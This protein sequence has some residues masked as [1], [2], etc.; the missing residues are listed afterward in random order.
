[1]T[2]VI[3]T[4]LIMSLS[5]G[6]LALLLFVLK[7]L[8][9]DRL[10]KSAQYY[11]WLVVFAALLLPVSVI[12]VLPGDSPLPVAPVQSVVELIVVPPEPV[13]P[14]SQVPAPAVFDRSIT[15]TEPE[16][17][18]TASIP[19]PLI[20]VFVYSLGVLITLLYYI[21]NYRIFIGLHRSRSRAA[22]AASSAYSSGGEMSGHHSASS[23]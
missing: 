13:V 22:N 6:I 16:S 20:V 14:Q 5:G 21:I 2:D 23:W 17:G 3:S 7:P 4:V 8:V 9:R 10:P 1:M 18:Q 15:S 19:S 12:V 11:L